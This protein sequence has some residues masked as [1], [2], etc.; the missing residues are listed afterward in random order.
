[1]REGLVHIHRGGVLGALRR[2]AGNRRA[3]NMIASPDGSQTSTLLVQRLMAASLGWRGLT[4]G[5]LLAF[6]ALLAWALLP[7]T[8]LA[9]AEEEV[10]VSTLG[11]QGDS[12]APVGGSGHRVVAQKFSAPRVRDYT[13]TEVTLNFSSSAS[14]V[15]VAIHEVDVQNPASSSLYELTA[16]KRRARG[17]GPLWRLRTRH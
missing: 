14:G 13:L 5:I 17:T 6:A 4:F 3:S 9:E 15:S 1:M 2:I 12:G 7:G 8:L 16:L 10:L 11:E